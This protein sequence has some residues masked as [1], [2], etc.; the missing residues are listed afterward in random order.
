[1]SKGFETTV[2]VVR[3]I[4]LLPEK[5]IKLS[6]NGHTLIKKTFKAGTAGRKTL[7]PIT[8]RREVSEMRQ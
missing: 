6:Q 4:V 8:L 1:M 5:Q 7:D 3:E 2:Q